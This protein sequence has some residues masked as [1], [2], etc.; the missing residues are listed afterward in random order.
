MNT[1]LVYEVPKYPALTQK[2]FKDV[3]ELWPI[4]FRENKYVEKLLKDELLSSKER[5]D[6]SKF[7][8]MCLNAA[9]HGDWIWLPK[10]KVVAAG[11][12]TVNT[13]TTHL[14]L[15]RT[16]MKRLKSLKGRILE[17]MLRNWLFRISGT[18]YDAYLSREPC[19]M[20]AMAL[21]HSR[22][23]RVFYS[24]ST[25]WGALGSH[26]KL[27]ILNGLNHHYEVFKVESVKHQNSMEEEKCS[28][29][30]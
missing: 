12:L 5:E 30:S 17:K 21:V 20:C 24:T 6:V 9:Q 2:Q 23:R 11:K 16:M 8:K 19:V 1:V 22:I 3:S 25:S 15:K 13:C 7:M 14:T 29:I 4:Q 28:A 18:S 10:A 27:H 26:C